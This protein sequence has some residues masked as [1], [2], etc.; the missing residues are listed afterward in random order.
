MGW[1]QVPAGR[2]QHGDTGVIQCES[3]SMFEQRLSRPGATGRLSVLRI[4]RSWGPAGRVIQS[5]DSLNDSVHFVS[6]EL[7]IRFSALTLRLMRFLLEPTEAA[8][9]SSRP[10]NGAVSDAVAPPLSFPKT[11]P[12]DPVRLRPAQNN[13]NR[14]FSWWMCESS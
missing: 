7:V 1:R 8:S 6:N 13:L 10:P 11:E 2:R 14:S 5:F 3:E 4:F 9:S 12:I